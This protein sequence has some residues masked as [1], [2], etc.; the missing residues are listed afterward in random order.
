MVAPLRTINLAQ[1]ERPR[2][3]EMQIQESVSLHWLTN[4]DYPNQ[5]YTKKIS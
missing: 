2:C 4:S 1:P 3:L 5:F